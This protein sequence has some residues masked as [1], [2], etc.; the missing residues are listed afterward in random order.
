M[1]LTIK[2]KLFVLTAL[3]IVVVSAV[4]AVSYSCIR[5]LKFAI[6]DIVKGS[7]ILRNHMTA[8]MMHDALNSDVQASLLAAEVA[9]KNR[10]G[11]ILQD[12]QEHASTFKN[13]LIDNEK[14]VTETETR[15]ALQ[16]VEPA[17]RDY[18]ASAGKII[19]LAGTDRHA[20]LANVDAF[21]HTFD[22]LADE[23][24]AL[25]DLIEKDTLAKQKA[26]NALAGYSLN[27]SLAVSLFGIAIMLLVAWS[28]IKNIIRSLNA[29]IAV[30]DEVANGDLTAP[31][32]VHNADEIGRLGESM[33]K[34]RVRLAGVITQ[35]FDTAEKLSTAGTEISAIT[36]KTSDSVKSQ[37]AETEQVATA[38]N[39]MTA[40]V[41]E[42][43]SHIS[44]TASA[45]N[46]A[47]VETMAGNRVVQ[48][49]TQEILRLETQ[50]SEA[51]EIINRLETSSHN[52]SSVLD[53]I[54]NIAEQTNLLALNAAIEA[55]R[56]GE[57]GRGFAVV[58]DEVRSLASRTQQSTAEINAMIDQLQ[59]GAKEAVT[60]IEIS[61]K[62]TVLVVDHAKA[63]GTSLESISSAVTQISDMSVQIASAAEEQGAVSDEINRNIL[64]INDMT[65]HAA[66]GVQKT[67]VAA[68]HLAEMA[69]GLQ[70]VVRQFRV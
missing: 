2:L 47:N 4:G 12:Y 65:H 22:V 54:S 17:L 23:M 29:L 59:S 36:K 49:A 53:V 25:T 15:A 28:T 64:R 14:W 26:G 7:T 46:N 24:E 70:K 20:A 48:A 37:Q 40:T 58:A 39:E 63:A 31:I 33:E 13:A 21:K 30:A 67:A 16:K 52:I 62:Q 50:I 34:M 18:I 3:C 45:A 9:D 27:V 38:M 51:A 43:S 1:N 35:I 8:D 41:H 60:A 61:R 19:S 32:P 68:D 44:L 42:V 6:D 10:L 57:T 55:A 56:A 69:S 5:N 66:T 11:A